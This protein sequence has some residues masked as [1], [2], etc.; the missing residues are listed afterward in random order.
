MKRGRIKLLLLAVSFLLLAGYYGIYPFFR[1][2]KEYK[3]LEQK[4]RYF[5]LSLPEEAAVPEK[6]REEALVSNGLLLERLEKIITGN[7]CRV[8]H[9]T[10][11]LTCR[12][13]GADV[14]T[15][16]LL[17][18]GRFVNLLRVLNYAEKNFPLCRFRSVVYSVET[19]RQSRK[20]QL[21]LTLW[22]QQVEWREREQE[23]F[24]KT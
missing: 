9:Y 18:T 8:V 19:D 16:E 11:Y 14:Y 6:A 21:Y 22:I 17:L 15:G 7:A 23:S 13:Q 1:L 24:G 4:V 2:W 5:S 10:P 12:E 3:D 20:K